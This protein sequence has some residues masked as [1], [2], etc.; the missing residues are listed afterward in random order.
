[1]AA[2]FAFDHDHGFFSAGDRFGIFNSD[3]HST[4][5]VANT[6]MNKPGTKNRNDDCANET[7]RSRRSTDGVATNTCLARRNE[8]NFNHSFLPHVK[9]PCM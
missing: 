9:P 4:S 6:W 3:E 2:S 5:V 7:T 8:P 1:M